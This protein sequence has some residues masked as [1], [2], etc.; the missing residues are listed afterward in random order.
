MSDPRNLNY[1]ERLGV[2]QDATPEEIKA[3]YKGLRK[4]FHPDGRPE[5]YRAHF[6]AMMAGINEARDALLDPRQR[7]KHD[8]RISEER[9][10]KAQAGRQPPRQDHPPQA[11][12]DERRR[13][14]EARQKAERERRAW[15]AR[16]SQ[17]REE[18]ERRR[19]EEQAQGPDDEEWYWSEEGDA[20]G[21]G[22]HEAPRQ[23]PEGGDLVPGGGLVHR[24]PGPVHR[25]GL[26]MTGTWAWFLLAGA[27]GSLPIPGAG[28]V[29]FVGALGASV[30]AGALWIKA[31]AAMSVAERVLRRLVPGIGRFTAIWYGRRILESIALAPV[32]VFLGAGL[33]Y[34]W[35]LASLAAMVY[36]G[37]WVAEIFGRRRSTAET[38][39]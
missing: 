5:S 28:L 24:L 18:E 37:L 23:E 33:S 14:E 16:D 29:A 12:Q 15:E 4:Q 13:Q 39:G 8:R 9:L 10:K 6:D 26:Y 36:V 20:P 30:V 17:R 2:P 7:A 32:I 34:I 31:G 21:A 38:G 19:A 25:A 22:G 27:V 11:D 35:L 3:A 1:Y